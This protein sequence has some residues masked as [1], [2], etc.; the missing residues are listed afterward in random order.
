MVLLTHS[1][2]D[3]TL[4]E[5]DAL[6]SIVQENQNARNPVLQIEKRVSA[7]V[8]DLCNASWEIW[9]SAL[10][11]LEEKEAE[12]VCACVSFSNLRFVLSYRVTLCRITFQL[13]AFIPKTRDIW[14]RSATAQSRFCQKH[15]TY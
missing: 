7:L 2:A 11:F 13:G 6:P 12:A 10:R 3:I 14:L 1:K 4:E 8:R 5:C 15:I 9:P